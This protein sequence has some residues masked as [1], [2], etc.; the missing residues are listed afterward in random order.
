MQ[1]SKQRK[2]QM[3]A[4]NLLFDPEQDGKHAVR[5]AEGGIQV[6]VD[7]NE[8]SIQRLQKMLDESGGSGG[9]AF[10]DDESS[11]NSTATTDEY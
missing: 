1:L 7:L 11:G 8:M 3:S 9:L 10:L 4:A 5:D 2:D 6:S